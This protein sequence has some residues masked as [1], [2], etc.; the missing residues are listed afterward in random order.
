MKAEEAYETVIG[1]EVHA[2]LLTKTKLF[3]ADTTAFGREANTQVSAISLAHP[4]TLPKMNKEA[5]R[6]AITLGLATGSQIVQQNY[7]ARKNYFYP[8]LPKGYQISQHTTPIC[9]GGEL[10]IT[11]GQQ[12]RAVRLNRI[13]IEE[14]AGK[15]IHDGE[16]LFTQL[17]FNRAGT[18]L[19]EI[20]TEPD[21]RSA[22]E[23]AAYVT[24]LRKLVR[25]LGVCDGNM[26]EGSMRCDVNISVRK[27]GDKKLGTRVEIKNLNSIR[28]IKKAIEYESKELIKK[29]EKGET[30]LQQTKGLDDA[31]F[32]TYVIRT[33][34][35]EDDYRYF[36]EP[37]LPPFSISTEFIESV[38]QS[39]PPL[40]SEIK[41]KVQEQYG[42]P[43]YDASLLAED[44]ELANYFF[45]LTENTINYKAAANW[46]LGPI[47]NHLAENETAELS[48]L[49]P[50]SVAEL[51]RLIDE[52]VIS[53]GIAQKIFPQLLANPAL[54]IAN[55]IKEQNLQMQSGSET[56]AHIDAALTKHAQ[57]I[58]EYKKGKK[59]L[60]S[61]F[62]GEVMK[63][64]K[65][66]ANAEEV[67][68]RIL[69]KINQQA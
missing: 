40:Q 41:A 14:D 16:G 28:Y 45:S 10:A 54:D 64:S 12:K 37:D 22:E 25:H 7:F 66:K 13:H 32:I 69:E 38:K 42:L 43:E 55:Y 3:C 27:K 68:K 49:P 26:E 21:L 8:D 67:T 15:S 33:K 24:T 51:V 6:L 23:A 61:L 9:K 4:G 39:I 17:D 5:I 2:Q 36:P 50:A 57:K 47:K 30:I 20:V 63:L 29:L 19:L 53:Y 1:L 60:L 46:V 35:D 59:G 31:S 11:V 44:M 62:V 56:E 48:A 65:G 58:T 52:A 34:E 18:P